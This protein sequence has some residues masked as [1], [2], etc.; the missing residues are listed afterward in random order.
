M[1]CRLDR[2]YSAPAPAHA[3]RTCGF[4]APR[5]LSAHGDRAASRAS[6]R[7]TSR[8]SSCSRPTPAPTLS[9]PRRAHGLGGGRRCSSCHGRPSAGDERLRVEGRGDT[10]ARSAHPPRPLDRDAEDLGARGGG[11][12]AHLDQLCAALRL[13][14]RVSTCSGWAPTTAAHRH[15]VARSSPSLCACSSAGRV[16]P[17]EGV[18]QPEAAARPTVGPPPP[19]EP[20]TA[21]PPSPPA[22]TLDTS[23]TSDA[24]GL[25]VRARSG[26]GARAHTALDTRGDQQPPRSRFFEMGVASAPCRRAAS[27]RRTASEQPG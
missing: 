21:P 4:L 20:V 8:P 22:N 6:R 5:A 12:F 2:G 10:G 14:R 24:V 23:H 13:P 1:V 18:S 19:P 25:A 26:R 15:C 7:A 27:C 16:G 17:G 11:V 3:R 9:A